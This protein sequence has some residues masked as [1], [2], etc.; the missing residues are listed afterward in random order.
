M[1]PPPEIKSIIE[2][3]ANY[4]AKN[5]ASFESMIMKVE[6]NNIKFNF[7]KFNDDPYRPFYF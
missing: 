2:K 7:L 6:A 5:G 3:T 4:V 1:I